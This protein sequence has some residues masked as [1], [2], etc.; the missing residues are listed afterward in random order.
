MRN[1]LNLSILYQTQDKIFV[2]SP[3][4]SCFKYMIQTVIIL[5]DCVHFTQLNKETLS[6][7]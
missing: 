4:P 5:E 6:L 2:V 1:E 3:K 7:K